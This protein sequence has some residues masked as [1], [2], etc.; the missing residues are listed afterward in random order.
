MAISF[1]ADFLR[2]CLAC[3]CSLSY[4]YWPAAEPLAD[5]RGTLGFHGTAVEN[6]S[7]SIISEAGK[8]EHQTMKKASMHSMQARN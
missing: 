5:A 3:L 4:F 2:L 8:L 1:G 7:C 6:H